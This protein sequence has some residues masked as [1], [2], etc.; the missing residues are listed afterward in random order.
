MERLT[1]PKRLHPAVWHLQRRAAAGLLVLMMVNATSAGS[2]FS[3]DK[4]P[5]LEKIRVA[6]DDF[7]RTIK[8][9]EGKFVLTRTFGPKDQGPTLGTKTPDDR[10]ETTFSAEISTRRA[11]LDNS[12]SINYPGKNGGKVNVVAHVIESYDGRR[13]YQLMHTHPQRTVETTIPLDVPS[14]LDIS[15]TTT[16]LSEAL[17]WNWSGLGSPRTFLN[18]AELLHRPNARVEAQ[19]MIDGIECTRIG[20]VISIDSGRIRAEEAGDIRVAVWLDPSRGF[21]L[22]RYE[23]GKLTLPAGKS[24]PTYQMQHRI[25]VP[26]YR[27][28]RDAALGTDRWFPSRAEVR[29]QADVLNKFEITDLRINAPIS[30]ER[31]VIDAKSLPDG[32]QVTDS[33]P[34]V[35]VS[36]PPPRKVWY[37]GDREDIWRERRA[38]TDDEDARIAA[39]IAI[40]PASLVPA[41]SAPDLIPGTVSANTAPEGNWTS[42]QVGIASCLLIILGARAVIRSRRSVS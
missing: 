8:T 12:I 26:E 14:R 3:G 1:W 42:W 16:A 41:G 29:Y 4:P 39:L 23:M 6:V 21:L 13:S 35:L 33:S 11:F 9:L 15:P 19:E 18:L 34:G 27:Q 22:K 5:K 40:T 7:S 25:D 2:A 20:V 10:T 32:V 31:F 28:F 17:P 38:L 30:P 37:T 36:E 24:M